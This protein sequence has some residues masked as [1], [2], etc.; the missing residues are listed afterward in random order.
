MIKIKAVQFGDKFSF[1]TE[2]GD[3]YTASLEFVKN[4]KKK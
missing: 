3:L 4:I 2:N 1:V